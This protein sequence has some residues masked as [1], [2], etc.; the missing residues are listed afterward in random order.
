MSRHVMSRQ[1]VTCHVLLRCIISCQ[2]RSYHTM[3]CQ[4]VS[5]YVII[6]I[7]WPSKSRHL[8]SCHAMPVVKVNL[9]DLNVRSQLWSLFLNTSNINN[10]KIVHLDLKV[11]KAYVLPTNLGAQ[12]AIKRSW[13]AWKKLT[14]LDYYKSNCCSKLLIKQMSV[15]R[16]CGFPLVTR[17]NSEISASI[18]DLQIKSSDA[19][20]V[21]L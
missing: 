14:I 16:T 10:I 6:A 9:S 11:H 19:L 1:S 5:I 12:K 18:H 2:V 8:M 4:V 17:G 13:I 21:R 15:I 20:P 7:L 3:S